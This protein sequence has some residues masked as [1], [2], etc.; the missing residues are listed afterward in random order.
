RDHLKIH[1]A[2][3][4][5]PLMSEPELRELGEDIKANGLRAPIVLYKGKLLDGRNRLDAMQL[6]GVK[7]T[8]S[9]QDISDDCL[10]F[11][12]SAAQRMSHTAKLRCNTYGKGDPYDYV[13]S[14]NLH[15]RHLTSEQKRELIAKVLKAK[16]EASNA[17][18]AKQ[19]KA[20]D[21]T[22]AKIRR[23]LEST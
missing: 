22:V 14:A 13:L 10:L 23:K 7:V 5:F 12:G 9:Y 8:L 16:P 20:D 19:V 17:T 2:A 4:L 21:K 6:V 11:F 3:D 15:R 1:P 18:V